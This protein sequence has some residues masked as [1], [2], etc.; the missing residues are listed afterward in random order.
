MTATVDQAVGNLQRANADLQRRL[1]EAI[2]ERDEGEAQK[3]AM[4]QILEVINSSPGDPTPVFDGILEKAHTLCGAAHG[5]LVTYDGEYF[6]G[7]ATHGMSDHFAEVVRQ[8]VRAWPGSIYERL[9]GGE[10]LT[11]IPDMS[12]RVGAG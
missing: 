6:R 2:A 11:H 5:A 9:L 7:V 3:A 1:D 10:Q 12:V 4:A 8:P